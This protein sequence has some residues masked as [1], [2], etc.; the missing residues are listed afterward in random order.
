M[1][2]VL[3]PFTDLMSNTEAWAPWVPR[4]ALRPVFQVNPDGGPSERPALVISGTGSVQACGCW[5][6]PLPALVSGRRYRVEVLFKA[7]GVQ[8]LGNCVRAILTAQKNGPRFYAHLD[9]A[10]QVDGWHQLAITLSEPVPELI[11]H[12][13]FAWSASGK[14]SWADARCYEVSEIDEPVL[15]HV[16]AISGNPDKPESPAQCLD[17]YAERIESL[18]QPVDLICLPELINVT[19]LPGSPVDWA[20][21]IP[22]PTSELLSEKAKEKGA[23]IAASIQERRGDAIYNTGFLVD[24]SGGL[25]GKYRKTHLTLSEGLLQGVAPG[26]DFPL[27]PTDFGLLAYM[28]CYDGHFP[29]VPRLLGLQGAQIILFSNMGDGR[30][31]GDLWESV[32]RT[33]AVDNQV[34]IVA[35]VNSG[36]SCIVSP[37]GEFLANTDRTPGAVAQAT[38]DLNASLCD[39]TKRPIYRRYDQL[40][41]ADLFGDLAR[42]LWE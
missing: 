5:Q 17:F 29:E 32:V 9:D 14:V 34:H 20:E 18:A 2:E 12:L 42:H 33:R 41:R 31:G 13:F 24:R 15:V 4:E 3:M 25:V 16:A 40:R 8:A 22:G 21:P 1:N 30:E 35:A 39:S 27:F 28:I 37:K 36:R 10:G 26:N 38:C 11:L 6:L 7:E 23:Y 19:R